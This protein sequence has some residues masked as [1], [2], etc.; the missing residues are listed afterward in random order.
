MKLKI[1]STDRIM[2]LDYMLHVEWFNRNSVTKNTD[3]GV[4]NCTQFINRLYNNGYLDKEERF[5]SF[6]AKAVVTYIYRIKEEKK[7]ELSKCVR[8]YWG[9]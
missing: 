8:E 3:I 9:V 6:G 2:A 7:D 4:S 1:T 5:A